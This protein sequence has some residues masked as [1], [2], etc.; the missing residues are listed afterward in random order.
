MHLKTILNF[1]HPLKSFV[2]AGDR[3]VPEPDGGHILEVLVEPR[4]NGRPVCSGCGRSGSVYDHSG[5]RRYDFVPLWGIP[6]VLLYVVRR[7]NCRGCGVK[8]EQVPWSLGK[9]PVSRP[10]ALHLADWAKVLPWEEVARRFGVNWHQ[11]FESVKCAVQWGLARRDLS[12]VRALGIDEI[13]FGKGQ[14]YLTVVYQLCGDVRR[15]LYVGQRRDSETLQA[16]LDK[17]GTAWCANIEHVCTDMW[18]PYLKV[19]RERLLNAVH[20]LD[21]FHV[22]K[23]LNEAVD[24][25]RREEAGKLRKEGVDLL[26]GMRYVFLRRNEKLTETQAR[27]LN[28][29]LS[30]PWLKTV[31]AYLWKEKFDLFWQMET[32]AAARAYLRDW[33]KRANLSRLPPLKKFIKTMRA[34]EDLLMNWFEAKKLFSSG[35]VEGM[36]RKVNLITR[37][38]YGYRSY[39]VLQISLFHTLGHLP[40]PERTHRF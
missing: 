37:K 17:E 14:Q 39:E 2:Y 25:V 8:V 31:R 3:M 16:F 6:V 24:K 28:Q 10:L 36:N 13:Q 38:S 21:R 12:G 11:V 23:L 15:L 4:K 29:V 18:K 40:E 20:I 32:P 19:I 34:H 9:S 30:K 5:L 7:V 35:A 1:V 27:R 26:K 22:V 33:C